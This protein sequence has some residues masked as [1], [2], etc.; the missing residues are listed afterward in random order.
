M[1]GFFMRNLVDTGGTFVVAVI[2][3]NTTKKMHHQFFTS[4]DKQIQAQS[5]HTAAAAQS[6]NLHCNFCFCFAPTC[7]FYIF[8]SA[9]IYSILFSKGSPI[10]DA[11]IDRQQRSEKKKEIAVV[12]QKKK[13]QFVSAHIIKHRLYLFFRFRLRFA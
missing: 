4:N 2:A 7:A 3:K 11:S 10:A 1:I 9:L 12:Q 8:A 5:T 13:N 6:K